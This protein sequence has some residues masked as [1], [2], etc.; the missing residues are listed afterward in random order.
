M[1]GFRNNENC[2]RTENDSFEYP[3]PPDPP[4]DRG[5]VEAIDVDQAQAET[6]TQDRLDTVRGR[7]FGFMAY[8]MKSGSYQIESIQ[9]FVLRQCSKCC[10]WSHTGFQCR[11]GR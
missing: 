6:G 8:W 4:Y 2:A 7:K 10:E 3:R 11:R 1:R 5:G 9:N